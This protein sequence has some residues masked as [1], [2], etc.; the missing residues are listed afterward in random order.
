ML[1]RRLDL[2]EPAIGG[3]RTTLIVIARKLGDYTSAR[4]LIDEWEREP[5]GANNFQMLEFRADVEFRAEAYLPALDAARR[6]LAK[7]PT[8]A[9]MRKMEA[10]CLEKLRYDPQRIAPPPRLK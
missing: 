7:E 8:D 6:V 1:R 9:G 5:G 10:D 4:R 2:N 3:R